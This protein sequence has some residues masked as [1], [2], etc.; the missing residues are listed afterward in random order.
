MVKTE[1]TTNLPVLIYVGDKQCHRVLDGFARSLGAALEKQGIEVLY[2]DLS[3]QD[4]DSILEY[5]GKKL[6]AVVGM[7]TFMFS[8]KF[9]DGSFVHDAIDAPLFL[10]AFDHPIW[11]RKYLKDS[12][13]RLV[14]LTPDGNYATFIRKYYQL[15]ADF[16]PGKFG[17]FKQKINYKQNSRYQ[18]N[19]R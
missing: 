2:Y 19:C 15:M 3:G 12:P 16:F 14:V 1:Q 10:F 17:G 5:A 8:L 4:M 11:L 13:K 9:Q 7:Q 18:Q 6:R